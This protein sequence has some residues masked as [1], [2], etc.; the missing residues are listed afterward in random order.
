MK[1]GLSY[2]PA[3]GA[4]A[5]EFQLIRYPCMM[6]VFF[7]PFFFF[8]KFVSFFF[9]NDTTVKTFQRQQSLPACQQTAKCATN[10]MR[11]SDERDA[12]GTRSVQ[13]GDC[14]QTHG[15]FNNV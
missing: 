2:S 10:H 15:T 11:E 9:L 6:K 5:A 8:F 14:I 7:F 3:R 13:G 12:R 4:K 1:A